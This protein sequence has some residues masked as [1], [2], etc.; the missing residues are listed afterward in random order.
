M[1]LIFDFI[2]TINILAFK[3]FNYRWTRLY[4]I[5]K[6]NSFK[7]IY[8]VFE[9]DDAVLRGMYA[10]NRLKRFHVIMIFDVSSRYETPAPFDDG[11]DSVVNFANVFQREDLGVENL[12]FEGKNGNNK[13]EDEDRVIKDK[14]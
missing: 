9:L 2:T 11:N 10:D 8:R 7:G 12:V 14:K 5:I 4:C 13:I 6:S 1:V 3:K